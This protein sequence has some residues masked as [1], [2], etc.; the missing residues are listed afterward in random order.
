[1][2]HLLEGGAYFSVD[3]Q[4][5]MQIPKYAA[6]I[7]RRPLFEA[8]CLLEE[9]QYYHLQKILRTYKVL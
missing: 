8:C 5:S 9:I 4:I 1:M 3:T 6:L 2:G 7:R